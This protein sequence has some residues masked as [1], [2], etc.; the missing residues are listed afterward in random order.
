MT[1]IIQRS[2]NMLIYKLINNIIGYRLYVN[3]K[4]NSNFQFKIFL[5]IKL[6]IYQQ[7]IIVQRRS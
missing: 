6:L 3:E 2:K 5:K 1:K 4:K 7:N